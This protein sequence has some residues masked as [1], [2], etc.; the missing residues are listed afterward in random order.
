MAVLLQ[1]VRL[2][3]DRLR[4]RNPAAAA[5]AA[6]RGQQTAAVR[7]VMDQLAGRIGGTRGTRLRIAV[8]RCEDLQGLWHL[9]ASFMQALAAD[10]GELHARREIAGLDALFVRG[11]PGAPVSG[12]AELG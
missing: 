8:L 10:R 4:P 11:W 5:P 3:W 12:S 6:D 1:S 9:R 7:Q 2:L